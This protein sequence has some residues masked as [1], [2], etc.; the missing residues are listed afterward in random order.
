MMDEANEALGQ[1]VVCYRDMLAIYEQIH[2]AIAAGAAPA[3]LYALMEQVQALDAQARQ[4]DARFQANVSK[5]GI[6]WEE[7]ARFDQWK[8]LVSQLQKEVSQSRRHIRSAM[9]VASDELGRLAGGRQVLSGYHSGR[10]TTGRCINI[11][12]A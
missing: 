2:R 8:R 6:R 3:T 1:S 5:S 7:L 4:S 12:S 9:A 11:V 10:D